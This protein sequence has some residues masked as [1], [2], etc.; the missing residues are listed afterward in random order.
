MKPTINPNCKS[1]GILSYFSR[2]PYAL[3][4]IVIDVETLSSLLCVPE[5]DADALEAEPLFP[6]Y[7]S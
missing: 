2:F 3:T 7:A 4:S 5:P 1:F 6:K